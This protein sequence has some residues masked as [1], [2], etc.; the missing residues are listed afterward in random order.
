MTIDDLIKGL[1]SDSRRNETLSLLY[2]LFL[3]DPEKISESLIFLIN[4]PEKIAD[5]NKFAS[6][7]EEFS[8]ESFIEPLI[9]K[10][11][12]GNL[13]TNLWLADY[14]Y[15]LGSLL[16]EREDAW[17]ADQDF[18]K[19]LGKWLLST[20]GGEISWK[21]GIILSHLENSLTKQYLKQGVYDQSL[22]HQTRISCL[23]GIINQYRSEATAVL[24]DL[25]NDSDEYVRKAVADASQ[26]LNH[27]KQGF[28]GHPT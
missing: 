24:Q 17:P 19:L 13:D 23:Q 9:G 7:L 12:D 16:M 18:V 4:Q 22:F 1:N 28:R 6:L 26:W 25:A 15:A 21:A 14:M 3:S 5:T 10:I 20:G 8:S 11:R 27:A 2:D